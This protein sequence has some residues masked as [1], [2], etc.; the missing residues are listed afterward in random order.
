V[1]EAHRRVRDVADLR[2]AGRLTADPMLP[3]D[4]LGLY[5]YLP[6]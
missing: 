6:A 2:G 5:V 1:L 4:V 3:V